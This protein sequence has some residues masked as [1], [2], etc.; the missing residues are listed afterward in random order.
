MMAMVE[1]GA[2]RQ[3]AHE[4]IRE[5]SMLAWEEVSK[6]RKNNLIEILSKEKMV[7]KYIKIEE[8]NSFFKPENHI[9][10][11]KQRTKKF[12]AKLLKI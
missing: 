4:L 9:G 5:N 8:I 12:L 10:T 1:R 2:D 7:L 6:G 11:A 3:E